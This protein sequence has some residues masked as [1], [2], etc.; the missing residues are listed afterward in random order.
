MQVDSAFWEVRRRNAIAEA[1][2]AAR[3]CGLSIVVP[4]ADRGH[5]LGQMLLLLKRDYPAAYASVCGALAE[6]VGPQP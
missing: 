3:A 4:A 1:N 5:L 6:H 2:A